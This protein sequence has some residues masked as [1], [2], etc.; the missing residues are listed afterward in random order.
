MTYRR[1]AQLS[2]DARAICAVLRAEIIRAG[3]SATARLANIGRA[4]LHRAFPAD[5]G[6]SAPSFATVADVAR[7]LGLELTAVPRPDAVVDRMRRDGAL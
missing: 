5:P 4:S 2:P 6:K 3:W 7:A 1:R